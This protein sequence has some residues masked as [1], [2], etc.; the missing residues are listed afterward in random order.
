P[1]GT[2]LA[3]RGASGARCAAAWLPP[4]HPGP[5]CP[6]VIRSGAVRRLSRAGTGGTGL[7]GPARAP[8]AGRLTLSQKARTEHGALAGHAGGLVGGGGPR[9][10]PP[11]GAQGP[12]RDVSQ[13][14]GPTRAAS[15]RTLGLP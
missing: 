3:L 10:A 6:P 15:D 5:R 13:P 2:R 11:S 1:R 4:G 14:Q 12:C 8:V 7:A 9:V